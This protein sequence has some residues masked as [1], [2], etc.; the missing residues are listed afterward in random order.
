MLRNNQGDRITIKQAAKEFIM[1][2]AE[3]ATYYPDRNYVIDFD[4]A[5]DVEMERLGRE[6]QR[7]LDRVAR[8]LNV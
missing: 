1:D 2:A 7:Q 3:G 8:F 5:T 4:D 6:I